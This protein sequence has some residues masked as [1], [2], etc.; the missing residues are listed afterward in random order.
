MRSKITPTTYLF[1]PFL[2]SFSFFLSSVKAT[3]CMLKINKQILFPFL[4][5]KKSQ[6]KQQG[7]TFNVSLKA[8]ISSFHWTWKHLHLT[9]VWKICLALI[10][11]CMLW[12]SNYPLLS[13]PGTK[14]FLWIQSS[15]TASCWLFCIEGV[16]TPLHLP[17][18]CFQ[19]SIFIS[20]NVLFLMKKSTKKFKAMP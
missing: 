20:M 7:H 2:S 18:N 17:R 19:S 15:L 5:K 4:S 1:C 14:D 3:H 12:K 11:T 8:S 10:W 16:I 6:W 9:Q 13:I